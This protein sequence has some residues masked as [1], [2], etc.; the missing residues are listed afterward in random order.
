MGN[1]KKKKK[2]KGRVGGD[3]KGSWCWHG[4]EVGAGMDWYGKEER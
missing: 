2:K 1:L 3:M 4:K